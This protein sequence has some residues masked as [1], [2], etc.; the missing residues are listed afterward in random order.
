MGSASHYVEAEQESRLSADILRGWCAGQWLLERY[1][2]TETNMMLSNPYRGERRPGSVGL[3]L[4]GVEV[5]AVSE[6]TEQ[7]T[8]SGGPHILLCYWHNSS[9]QQLKLSS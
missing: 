5:R 3:P 1:G 7:P 2:M 8:E 6:D 9:A 4:P